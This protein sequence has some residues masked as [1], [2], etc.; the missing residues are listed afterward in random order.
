MLLGWALE[1]DILTRALGPVTVK[2]N[3]ALS[4]LALGF[5][6]WA[7]ARPTRRR[8]LVLA[9]KG[10]ALGAGALALL[11]FSQY[12]VGY[13][14]GIDQALF[15]EPASS[16]GTSVPGR[17]AP[18]TAVC[19]ALFA[20]ALLVLDRRS[21]SGRTPATWLAVAGIVIAYV[22]LLGYAA[23]VEAGIGTGLTQMAVVTATTLTVLGH[24]I[25][26]SRPERSPVRLV[27][28]DTPGGTVARALVPTLVLVPLVF[29][30]LETLGANAGSDDRLVDWGFDVLFV[31][32]LIP[33]A[34]RLAWYLDHSHKRG[35]RA[36][37]AQATTE[38]RYQAL[39]ESTMEAVVSARPDGK[40]IYANPAAGEL[41]GYAAG[42]L[43]G[44][45][46]TSLMPERFREAHETGMKR[47]LETGDAKVIGRTVELAGLT[48]DGE[49]FPLELSLGTWSSDDG[50]RFTGIIR[51]ITARRRAAQRRAIRDAVAR[52]LAE[53][54]TLHDALPGVLE[55]LV[56]GLGWR[57]GA[58][59]ICDPS[60]GRL[61]LRE[62]SAES[63]A[64]REQFAALHRDW[65]FARGEGVPGWVWEAGR[66]A[67]GPDSRED[68]RYLRAAISVELELRG[69][70]CVPIRGDERF[71]G[72]LEFYSGHREQPDDELLGLLGTVGKQLG[73]FIER[74]EAQ[75]AL[76]E[77][78][79]QH[80]VLVENLP[81]TAVM[82][83]D[84]DLRYT[85]AAGPALSVAS[86]GARNLEGKTIFEVF[87]ADKAEALAPAYRAALDGRRQ[88]FEYRSASD[89]WFWV[90]IVPLPGHG[91]IV[92]ALASPPARRPKRRSARFTRSSRASSGSSPRCSRTWPRG[93]S[94]ATPTD[95]SP[96]ST[97]RRGSSTG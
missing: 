40:I 47:F 48:R 81:R 63:G 72:T 19:V 24:G 52:P 50:V 93:W 38:M 21:A 62:V 54:H 90:Q 82:V 73:Q 37:R 23:G 46:L 42:E 32:V 70:V 27:L 71:H 86:H 1:L 75:R 20:A 97:A 39:V 7:L 6:L 35:E 43:V 69:T 9:G 10:A 83:F 49:E 68:E 25:L 85:L 29:E 16:A 87:P 77:S 56:S 95:D 91:G 12:L 89:R 3:A 66:P 4:F 67:W 76:E 84:R 13:D 59:W 8:G 60:A 41:F 28:C 74:R 61:R 33:L 57:V 51:D 88:A 31:A 65:S 2:A 14:L 92:A 26:W 96:C 44:A 17:M 94:P 22:A 45:P 11:T 36:E 64:L 15:D 78:E 5:A 55:A 58:A 34:W 79:L 18:N 80:R 30:G 53:T